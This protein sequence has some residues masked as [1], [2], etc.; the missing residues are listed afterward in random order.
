MKK[1]LG[2]LGLAALTLVGC[3]GQQANTEEPGQEE[4]MSEKAEEAGE[5]IKD[6]AGEVADEAKDKADEVADDVKDKADEITDDKKASD[7]LSVEL[8]LKEA[9]EIF[10]KE[11]PDAN[12]VD[13]KLENENNK[14]YYEMEGEST[15]K[16]FELKID[17][18]T[19]KIIDQEEEE[20][21]SQDP[22]KA[23]HLVDYL[24]AKEVV[25][26]AKKEGIDQIE[27]MALD[28]EDNG[29]VYWEVE[30]VDGDMEVAFDAM[31]GKVLEKDAD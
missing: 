9:S 18:D 26:L 7:P 19:G 13:L 10:E 25:K 27:S 15:D 22:D 16:D 5:D 31:T 11:Y 21:K 23:L 29:K 28:R 24:E 30:S 2:V 6:T 3:S 1:L 20:D 17:A 8:T 4:S 14:W 12:L